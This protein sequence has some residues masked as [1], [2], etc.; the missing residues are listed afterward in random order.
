MTPTNLF[1]KS[2]K[3]QPSSYSLNL[4][5]TQKLLASNLPLS[6]DSTVEWPDCIHATRNQGSCGSCYAFAASGM[7]SDRLCIKSNGQ[8]NLVLSPQELVSCDYQNYGCSGGWMTNTL[9]YLMSYGIPSETCLPYDMF[10]SE[11]KACSG[12]CDSPN[13]EYTRHKCKKGTSKIMSDPETIMRDIMENGPSIVAFQAFEDFLNFGGGIYKYTSG[14][15]LVGHATKLTGWGLDSAGRL[16]WIGQNQF[17]L[18]WG[19]RG[20]YGFYK[21]YDGEVGFGSAVW[22]CIPDV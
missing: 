10:N 7:M 1:G 2:I 13:Y 5:I 20:D 12:R 8:I 22:S 3:P 6:F 16:Y 21:I 9:Y 11:T 15:F 4:N 17:G 14:K 18:G 19:G